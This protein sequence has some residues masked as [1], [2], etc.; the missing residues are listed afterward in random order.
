MTNKTGIEILNTI[1]ASD[2]LKL[3]QLLKVSEGFFIE[4][5]QK[6]IRIDPVKILQIVDRH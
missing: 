3:N 1:V 5:H 4:N 6:F 2:D